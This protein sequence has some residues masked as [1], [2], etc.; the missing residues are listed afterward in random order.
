MM[1]TGAFRKQVAEKVDIL[2]LSR[3]ASTPG[4]A[5]PET[6]AQSQVECLLIRKREASQAEPS[7]TQDTMYRCYLLEGE[8]PT[9]AQLIKR[10]DGER[11]TILTKP[12][13]Y[14]NIIYFDC[15]HKS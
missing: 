5:I 6:T 1:L 8:T 2:D 10:S 12:E 15:Q 9:V 14:K 7:T 11:L 4:S 13:K 3:K